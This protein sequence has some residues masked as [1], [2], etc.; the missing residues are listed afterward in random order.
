LIFGRT[1]SDDFW[2]LLENQ[3]ANP[4]FSGGRPRMTFGLSAVF[5]QNLVKKPFFMF[6]LAREAEKLAKTAKL[7]FDFPI[8]FTR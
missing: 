3:N 6:N 5:R 1:G 4:L 2:L 7:V 8:V